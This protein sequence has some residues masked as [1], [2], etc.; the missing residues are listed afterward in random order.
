MY[1]VLQDR[2]GKLTLLDQFQVADGTAKDARNLVSK[3]STCILALNLT[4]RNGI[5]CLEV[6]TFVFS[7]TLT[8]ASLS[9]WVTHFW[10]TCT[11][12]SQSRALARQGQ[13]CRH[14]HLRRRLIEIANRFRNLSAPCRHQSSVLL[15]W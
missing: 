6:L 7:A 4:Q 12:T 8:T 9:D 1:S 10:R 11:K 13:S 3:K 14:P 5:R 15:F 2:F